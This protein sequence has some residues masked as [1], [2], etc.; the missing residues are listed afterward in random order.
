MAQYVTSY[1]LQP[2]TAPMAMRLTWIMR[3]TARFVLAG[4]VEGAGGD[5]GGWWS[6][7][8]RVSGGAGGT[9]GLGG[10]P[11]SHG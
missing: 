11:G 6:A 3:V 2:L 7:A 5:S 8:D 1:S 10:R 9:R 4:S